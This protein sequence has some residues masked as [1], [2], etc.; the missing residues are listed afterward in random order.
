MAPPAPFVS[1]VTPG[2]GQIV[3]AFVAGSDGGAPITGY[4]AKCTSS[5]GGTA[6]SVNGTGSPITVSG[7]SKT[8]AYTCTVTAKNAVGTGPA[9]A[10]SA[11]VVVPNA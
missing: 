8:K 9:S 2:V 3:V 5:N 4:T 6:K 11:S 1:S 7:L 10:P